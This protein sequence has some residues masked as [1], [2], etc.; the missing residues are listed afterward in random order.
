MF[1]LFLYFPLFISFTRWGT[2][3]NHHSSQFPTS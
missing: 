1:Y 3:T 2:I